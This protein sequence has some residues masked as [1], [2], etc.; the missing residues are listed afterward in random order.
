MSQLPDIV[1]HLIKLA[2]QHARMVLLEMHAGH[3]VTSWIFIDQHGAAHIQATPWQNDQEKELAKVMLKAQAR[4]LR[5][6]A[7]SFLS[8]AWAA[9]APK[10]WDPTSPL[11]EKDRPMHQPDRLEIVM[12]FATDGQKQLWRRWL[13]RRDW[14][15][16]IIG[17]EALDDS[18]DQP[19]EGWVSELL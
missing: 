15:E 1:D 9:A 13:I 16:Q 18:Y 19:P 10:D 6:R 12:A 5:T 3:L 4:K 8:E 2:E 17:L 7:Y 14:Q 11:P